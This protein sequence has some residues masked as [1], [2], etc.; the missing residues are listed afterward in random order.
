MPVRR[1]F[2]TQVRRGTLTVEGHT[3]DYILYLTPHRLAEK[4]RADIVAA[5]GGK[6][7]DYTADV[8]EE[9]I[10]EQEYSAVGIVDNRHAPDRALGTLQYYDWCQQGQPQ[11]WMND[12]C[13]VR[14]V[15]SRRP[16]KSPVAVLIDLFEQLGQ[17]FD[18]PAMHLAV[19]SK[20]GSRNRS[21]PPDIY[22]GYGFADTFCDLGDDCPDL[23]IEKAV[24]AKRDGW[25]RRTT[26]RRRRKT[27]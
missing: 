13:R 21:C 24:D 6:C 16:T 1:L 3:F 10:R 8:V 25:R 26:Y 4:D 9:N 11:L 2:P 7:L 12:L 18:I 5:L 27:S 17:E 23:I 20:G 19:E 22:V 15:G 14:D